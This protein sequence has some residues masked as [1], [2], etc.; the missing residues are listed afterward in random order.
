MDWRTKVKF[1][2]ID[3]RKANLFKLKN[4]LVK[5]IDDSFRCIKKDGTLSD[6][7]ET[8]DGSDFINYSFSNIDNFV[9]SFINEIEDDDLVLI[10]LALTATERDIF[11]NVKIDNPS[12]EI[13]QTPKIIKAIKEK[14]EN[15]KIMVMSTYTYLSAEKYAEFLSEICDEPWFNSIRYI[16]T[17]KVLD[18]CDTPKYKSELLSE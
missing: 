14:K 6:L 5:I 11:D 8:S 18:A 10:D 2:V 12:N 17:S 3:D 9:D 4:R 13:K 16:E 7:W 1:I 15:A